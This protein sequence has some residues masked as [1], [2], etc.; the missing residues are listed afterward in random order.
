MGKSGLSHR[1]PKF[2]RQLRLLQTQMKQ[3]NNEVRLAR[4]LLVQLGSGGIVPGLFLAQSNAHFL[5]E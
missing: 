4:R 3:V 1:I 5:L 2:Q